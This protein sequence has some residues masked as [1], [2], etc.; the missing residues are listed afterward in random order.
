MLRQRVTA[1][2]AYRTVYTPAK[3]AS[4]TVAFITKKHLGLGM[5]SAK[6]RSSAI[7]ASGAQTASG[8]FVG[9]I[10]SYVARE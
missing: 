6:H 1:S 5:P 9:E 3:N 8:S 10:A 7:S 4:R 2:A